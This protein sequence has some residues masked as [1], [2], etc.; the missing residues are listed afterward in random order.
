MKLVTIT[1]LVLKIPS[2]SITIIS[3]F[4]NVYMYI[5]MCIY[6]IIQMLT[7]WHQPVNTAGHVFVVSSLMCHTLSLSHTYMETNHQHMLSIIPHVY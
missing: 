5:T 2:K 3:Y 4:T 7:R 6:M 1:V